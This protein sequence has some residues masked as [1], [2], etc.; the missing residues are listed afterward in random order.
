LS[1]N[2]FEINYKKYVLSPPTRMWEF[3]EIHKDLVDAHN[4]VVKW[5]VSKIEWWT[6]WAKLNR[7]PWL[8]DIR[9]S[10]KTETAKILVTSGYNK[11]WWFEHLIVNT[12]A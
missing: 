12:S 10:I 7:S 4:T 6:N 1:C 8:S 3:Q 11:D 5:E 9:T 2:G